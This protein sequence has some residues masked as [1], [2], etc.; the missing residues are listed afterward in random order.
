[1]NKIVKAQVGLAIPISQGISFPA[2]GNVIS[3]AGSIASKVLPIAGG[4]PGV[5]TSILY[6]IATD[7]GS[8]NKGASQRHSQRSVAASDATR[9]ARPVVVPTTRPTTLDLH[10]TATTRVRPIAITRTMSAA[11]DSTSTAAPRDT[12]NA[13]PRDST[14]TAA[15]GS[16]NRSIR[17]KLGDMIAGRGRQKPK[18][19]P[20]NNEPKT[21]DQIIQENNARIIKKQ[22]DIETLKKTPGALFRVGWKPALGATALGVSGVA[23]WVLR[24]NKEVND[25][26]KVDKST[27]KASTTNAD[28]QKQQQDLVNS[29]MQSNMAQPQIEY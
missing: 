13:A 20:K 22:R 28:L 18:P 8:A 29:R 25:S 9:V 17:E 26:T 2:I 1:M 21:D 19:K 5:V 11:Q 4:V 7:R 24:G 6:N 15:S 12:T 23:G 27:N 14:G 3:K 10:R 16:D